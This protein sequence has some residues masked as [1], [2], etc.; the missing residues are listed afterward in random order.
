MDIKVSRK[1]IR[2]ER[3]SI[4]P[5]EIPLVIT[6]LLSGIILFLLFPAF[7]IFYAILWWAEV[8]DESSCLTALASPVILLANFG[9][10]VFISNIYI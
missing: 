3:F 10:W 5:N 8:D 7:F 2:I 1:P 6:L 4:E 9:Y